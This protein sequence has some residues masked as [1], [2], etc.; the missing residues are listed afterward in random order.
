MTSIELKN[1]LIRKIAGINDEAFLNALKI[2][3]DSKSESIIYKTI[4]EQQ[5]QIKEGEEQIANGEFFT[6]KQ[7]EKDID[8]QLASSDEKSKNT[9]RLTIKD[10]S[11]IR[12]RENSKRYKGSLSD[13]V[14]E[15]RRAEL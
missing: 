13:A 14:I 7:V 12:S 1:V 15:D 8:K 9:K 4:P 3:I 10:F 11:F 6:N 5:K 2:I